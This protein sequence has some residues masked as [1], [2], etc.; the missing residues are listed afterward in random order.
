[1][2]ISKLSPSQSFINCPF[3]HEIEIEKLHGTW[4]NLNNNNNNTFS[5]SEQ[6]PKKKINNKRA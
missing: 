4:L 2:Y 5:S 1:M 6:A 3:F